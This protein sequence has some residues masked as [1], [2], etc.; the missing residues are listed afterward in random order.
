M[1]TTKFKTKQ[2]LFAYLKENQD[3]LIYQKKSQFKKADGFSAQSQVMATVNNINKSASKA[4]NEV[5]QIKVRAI[6]NTTMI[7]D[8]HKDVHIDGLWKKSLKENSRIKHLQEHEMK[9]DKIISDKDDLT[10][11]TKTY[12]W[13]ELG[14]DIEGKTEALVFDSVV[15]QSRNSKM[16]NEYKNENVDNHS[17]GMYYVNIKMAINSDDDEYKEEKSIYDKHINDIANKDEVERVG[18]YYAVYE[19]KAIEGSAVPMGSNAITPTI[20]T[21]KKPIET[22]ESDIEKSAILEWLKS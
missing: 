2:E 22:K 17:V 6:I 7:M 3:D 14:Y 19:A 8:S 20:Q 1:D 4:D 13:K 18:F 12:E 16:F 10:A 5:D 21:S 9:F 15:K 11:F